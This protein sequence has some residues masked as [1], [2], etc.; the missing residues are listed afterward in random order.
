MPVVTAAT[1]NAVKP[2][3]P[4]P[5]APSPVAVLLF[6]H[7]K[8]APGVPEN[9]TA[10]GLPAQ[11][12]K[13]AGCVTTGDPMTMM[14]NVWLAPGQ[15]LATGV[16]VMVPVSTLAAVKLIL[17]EPLAPKPMMV[18]S[19]VQLNVGLLVPEKVTVTGVPAQT[20][21]LGGSTT[22]GAGSMMMVNVTGVPKQVPIAGVAVIV[23]T[24]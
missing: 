4:V 11:A 8:V 14:S 6:V 9:T 19:F 21:W 24:C 17:P 3:S 20:V 23:A 18:L 22:V 10:T 5:L 1:L 7:E 15:P 2:M 13:L 12:L 16:T